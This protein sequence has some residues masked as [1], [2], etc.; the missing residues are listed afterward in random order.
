MP[1]STEAPRAEGREPRATSPARESL[2]LIRGLGLVATVALVVGNMVGTSIYTLPATLAASTG[3]LGLVAWVV[4]AAGYLLVATVYASLGTR[5]PATGGPYVF[6]RA[7]FGDFAAFQT[8][9][10]YWFSAVIGNAAIVTGV[11]GYAVGF[12][13]A[14]AAS[15]PLQFALAQALLW[16]LCLLNVR[17]VRESGRF[18]V[19]VMV[20]NV[21][22][23][24]AVSLLALSRFDAAN[25]EPFAPNG[26]G[27]LA[28][29]AALI[30][31]AYSGVESATVPAEEVQAP[32]RTIRR[33]TMLGYAT[34]TIVFLV[35]ALAVAGSM[36][37]ALVASSARPLALMAERA[38]GEALGPALAAVIGI[39]AMIAGLGTLNGW[40]LMAGRIPLGAARDGLFFRGLAAVHPVRGTPHVALVVGT[41]VAST[42]L[43]LYFSRTLLGV[44]DF[45]VR[46]A[47]LTTLLPHLYAMAAELMLSRREGSRYTDRERRRA[48]IVAP[49][50]FAFVLYTIYGVGA[51]VALWGFLVVLAGI[52]MYVWLVTRDPVRTR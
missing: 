37:N 41:A 30:V 18:Q 44:F 33:G 48:A 29:G 13:S 31:W 19:A 35:S 9:W 7:A 17:G 49:L 20:L 36:P 27:S 38:G 14:L 5:Y 45:I 47:V 43:L 10:A 15:V 8:V 39:V 52:P 28:A 21:V 26:P 6:A 3:P 1:R 11:V 34:G 50:A 12:S 2:P 46:L 4:T 22:P 40:I 42:M 51:E 32:E 23:L 24:L 25:L 16:G